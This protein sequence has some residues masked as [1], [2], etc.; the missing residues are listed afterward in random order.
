MLRA[1]QFSTSLPHRYLS[2]N[3]D[4]QKVRLMISSGERPL[5]G[6]RGQERSGF[7]S[8][9]SGKNGQCSKGQENRTLSQDFAIKPGKY[10]N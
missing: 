6:S 7:G 1:T 8:S 2:M 3:I 5:Q 4:L 9:K 10:K